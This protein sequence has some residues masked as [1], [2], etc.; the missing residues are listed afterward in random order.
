MCPSPNGIGQHRTGSGS[1]EG[2]GLGAGVGE[3][4]GGRGGVGGVC[5]GGRGR[6]FVYG[7]PEGK[8]VAG[9]NK[10][11]NREFIDLV[12]LVDSVRCVKSE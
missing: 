10:K 8:S 7:C 11:R 2:V 3:W 6:I 5:C 9:G 4:V 1:K 12:I